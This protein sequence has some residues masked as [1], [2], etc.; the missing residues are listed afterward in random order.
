[1]HDSLGRYSVTSQAKVTVAPAALTVLNPVPSTVT[2]VAGVPTT[3]TLARFTS[4][5]P[6]ATLADFTATF[7]W[8]DS[9]TNEP[10]TIVVD[11]KG[12]FDVVGTHTYSKF[13]DLTD[14]SL[15]IPPIGISLKSRG[16][17]SAWASA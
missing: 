10:G 14:P 11:P 16:G 13:W 7:S 17:A 2:A 15:Q 3:L 12:G 9:T 4:A 5:N 1:M 6:L 8:G